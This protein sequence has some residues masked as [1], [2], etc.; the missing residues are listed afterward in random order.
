MHFIFMYFLLLC[1]VRASTLAWHV[2]ASVNAAE[3]RLKTEPF[4]ETLTFGNGDAGA[5]VCWGAKCSTLICDTL[6]I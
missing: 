3:L 4:T 5:R 6:I 1:F 2:E